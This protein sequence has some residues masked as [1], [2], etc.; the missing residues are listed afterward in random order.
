MILEMQV[1][2]MQI[3]V[4]LHLRIW[5]FLIADSCRNSERKLTLIG[6]MHLID[7]LEYANG[8][9]ANITENIAKTKNDPL[10]CLIGSEYKNHRDLVGTFD[11]IF[12]SEF[13]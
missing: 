6:I 5:F 2:N 4:C 9:V 7:L 1:G 10:A 12:P 3:F 13:I 11:Y 8:I